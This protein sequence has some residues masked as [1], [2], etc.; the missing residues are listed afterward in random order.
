MDL[1]KFKRLAK[2]HLFIL[3]GYT[4]DKEGNTLNYEKQKRLCLFF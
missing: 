2:K 3:E 4:I 1:E